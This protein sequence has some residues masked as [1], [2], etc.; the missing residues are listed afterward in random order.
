MAAVLTALAMIFSYIEM[1][2]PFSFGVPGIKLGLAN[3]VTVVALYT[4]G[5]GCAFSVNMLRVMLSGLLFGNVFA[6]L[7]SL[8]G[9][10]VS[11]AAMTLLKKTNLFSITGVS[12][13]GGVF[14]N[15]GQIIV[16]A[17]IVE[18]AKLFYYFPALLF[19]GMTTGI[20]M[21]IIA[22]SVCKRGQF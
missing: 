10:L 5:T 3:V 17:L 15:L 6:I 1:L 18:N 13:A 12:M 8:A 21:G 4:L 19:A 14:H 2:F 22:Y 7:Y 16:A 20:L 11:F 9:A